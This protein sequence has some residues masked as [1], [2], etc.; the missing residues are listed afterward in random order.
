[1][2]LIGNDWVWSKSAAAFPIIRPTDI[3]PVTVVVTGE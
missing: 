3:L 1:M 2:A